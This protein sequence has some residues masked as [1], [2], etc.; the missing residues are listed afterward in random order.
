MKQE[1]AVQPGRLVNIY[2]CKL[3]LPYIAGYGTLPN[4]FPEGDARHG[5]VVDYATFPGSAPPLDRG[6]TL[7][8]ELG[9]YF[10]LFHTFQGGCAAPGDEVEDTP[11]E[12]SASYGCAIGRDTCPSAGADPVQNFMDYSEDDCTTAFTAGQGERMRAAIA[13]F[14]P[15][16]AQQGFAIGPGITGNWYDPAQNGHGLSIEVLADQHLLVQWYTFAPDGG[17]AWLVGVGPIVGNAAVVDAYRQV[18]E[19]GRFP[20]NFDPG[21]VHGERWGT[22]RLEFADCDHGQMA[23]QPEVPGYPAGSMPLGRLTLPA[24]LSCP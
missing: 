8:H 1:L 24:G 6:H 11:A 12:A 22:L 13:A 14:R 19:G 18:G 10:G 3:A 9:H 20:P 7:V 17:A 4:E 16:L 2:S 15:Q 23:W 21:H 5:V